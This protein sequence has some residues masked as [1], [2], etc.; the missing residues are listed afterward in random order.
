MFCNQVAYFGLDNALLLRLESIGH[1]FENPL[2]ADTV[3]LFW[4]RFFNSQKDLM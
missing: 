1:L 4:T 2:I 3:E